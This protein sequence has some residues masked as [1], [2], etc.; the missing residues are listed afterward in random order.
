MKRYRWQILLALALIMLSV[1][2]YGIHY[3]IFGD[4]HHIYI[5]MLGDL[6]FVPIEVL[7]VT[8]IVHRLLTE[9]EKRSRLE[10]LNMVIGVFFSEAGTGLLTQLSDCDPRLDEIRKNLV[11]RAE[12]SDREFSALSRTLKG[13]PFSIDIRKADVEGLRRFL[14]DKRDFLLRLLENPNL[15]EH[16]TFTQLLQAVFHLTEELADRDDLSKLPASD[17]EH[18]AGDM[19]RAYVLLVNEWVDYMKHLKNNYPFL[20]SL[21][22]R[23]NP[24]DQSASVIIK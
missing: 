15:L 2:L 1:I 16:E 4:P 10:K 3:A 19:K 14:L 9:R 7:L 24:F 8:I 13:Y 17:Y 23:T 6:A 18:L 20:F 12:W 21:A 11:P 5:Y 22:M